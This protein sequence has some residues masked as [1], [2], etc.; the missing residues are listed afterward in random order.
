[1]V[2]A[3]PT[4]PAPARIELVGHAPL[5]RDVRA[6]RG[7]RQA[8]ADRPD[9]L[10]D[11]PLAHEADGALELFG[12]LAPDLPFLLRGHRGAARVGEAAAEGRE[13]GTARAPAEARHRSFVRTKA[14]RGDGT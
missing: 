8:R 4:P 3:A 11:P 9:V 7:P 10:D 13:T 12:V 14:P 5:P 1:M 2:V 6:S